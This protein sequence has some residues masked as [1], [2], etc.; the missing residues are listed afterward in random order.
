MS[1]YDWSPIIDALIGAAATA[2]TILST[3]AFRCLREWLEAS[4][5][6]RVVRACRNGA[7]LVLEDLEA[8]GFSYDLDRVQ[9]AL[10]RVGMPYV[11]SGTAGRMIRS[12]GY[13]PEHVEQMLR[14]QM[15][16][17]RRGAADPAIATPA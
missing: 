2:I 9:E 8:A 11:N 15:A 14:T 5:V 6:A 3:Y 1:A 13:T 10:L 16:L 7:A 17:L 12:V 4:R